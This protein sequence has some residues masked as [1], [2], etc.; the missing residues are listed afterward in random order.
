MNSFQLYANGARL[1][2]DTRYANGLNIAGN[3]LEGDG[4]ETSSSQAH[5]YI[6]ADGRSQDFH[7]K[8]DLQVASL[9]A[10]NGLADIALGD[11]RLAWMTDQPQRAERYFAYVPADPASGASEYVVVA[12]RFTQG[13]ESHDYTSYLHTDWTNTMAVTSGSANGVDRPITACVTAPSHDESRYAAG[14]PFHPYRWFLDAAVGEEPAT[15]V[16]DAAMEATIVTATP[17]AATVGSFTPLDQKDWERYRLRDTGKRPQ[18]RLEITSSGPSFNSLAVLMPGDGHPGR[19]CAKGPTVTQV[20]TNDGEL[21][22]RVEHRKGTRDTVKLSLSPVDGLHDFRIERLTR[23]HSI[24]T[25]GVDPTQSDT[26]EEPL[27]EQLAED[28]VDTL[29]RVSGLPGA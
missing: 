3:G 14:E 28:P 27:D 29:R 24:V 23:S 9:A 13:G 8:G 5:N 15:V 11:A 12:D 18:P 21:V 16:R 22:L 6:V 17:A 7:G 26:D 20:R 19:R 1:V 25:A 2:V 4:A 10:H